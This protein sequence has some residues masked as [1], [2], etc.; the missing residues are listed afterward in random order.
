MISLPMIIVGLIIGLISGTRSNG[1]LVTLIGS[2]IGLLL[3]LTLYL[4]GILFIKLVNRLKQKNLGEP[5][6]GFG[7]VMLGCVIGLM[8]GWPEI[9]QSMAVTIL[10]AGLFSFLYLLV[11]LVFRRYRFGI[12]IPYAPFMITGA[13]Y[14]MYFS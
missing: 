9:L 13:I 2:L 4:F 3:M 5:A 10:A 1:I 8:I 6:M 12:A 7:D 14:V 11:M